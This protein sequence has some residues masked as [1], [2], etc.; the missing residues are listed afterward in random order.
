MPSQQAKPLLLN[1]GGARIL[2]RVRPPKQPVAHTENLGSRMEAATCMRVGVAANEADRLVS[3]RSGHQFKL[4]CIAMWENEPK[5]IKPKR[6]QRMAAIF[7]N[8]TMI[9]AT[10]SVL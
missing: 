5:P 2:R 10:L 9:S 6:Q 1:V 3:L 8:L 7:L 4:N